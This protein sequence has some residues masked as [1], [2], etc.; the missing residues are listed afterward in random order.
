MLRSNKERVQYQVPSCTTVL[1]ED[2]TKFF[3]LKKTRRR[4][5]SIFK[6]S[7]K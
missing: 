1:S 3:G 6:P 2:V 4:K 7:I 5:D